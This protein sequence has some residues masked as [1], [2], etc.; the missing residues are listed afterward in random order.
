MR[1]SPS[2][3][4]FPS[5]TA[6]TLPRCGFSLAV[7]GRTMPLAVVSSSSIAFTMRRSPRGLRLM[8]V[9]SVRV[10]E[11][12]T[13]AVRVP[14]AAGFPRPARL[15]GE[16]G[17]R[18]PGCYLILGW[19]VRA[20]PLADLGGAVRDLREAHDRDQVVHLDLAA[21]DLLE[22]VDHLVEAAEL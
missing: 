7:S 3:S 8:R 1:L 13:L 11:P 15:R 17:A 12:G 10:L 6:R 20:H 5:P 9:T 4:H 16:P 19:R 14:K 2:S 18:A 22:K 21:V